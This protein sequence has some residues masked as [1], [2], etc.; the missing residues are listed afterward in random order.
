MHRQASK[1]AAD[2][3]RSVQNG[4]FAGGTFDWATPFA[5]ACG[6][7]LAQVQADLAFRSVFEKWL[8]RRLGEKAPPDDPVALMAKWDTPIRSRQQKAAVRAGTEQSAGM[9]SD[10][11]FGPGGKTTPEYWI[12]GRPIRAAP[13]A[14]QRPVRCP[15]IPAVSSLCAP[16]AGREAHQRVAT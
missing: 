3:P 5:V 7:V 12:D 16:S 8:N 11:L 4:A 10:Q 2:D 14:P 6:L 9:L 13:K 15:S 1:L